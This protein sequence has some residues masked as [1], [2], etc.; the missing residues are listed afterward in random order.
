MGE[1][2]A[3]LKGA[4][5]LLV[6]D[7]SANLDVLC[8]LLEP[9]G[10][11]LAVATDGPMALKIASGTQPDLVLL[12]VMMPHMD[13]IE[14]C[15]RFKQDPKLRHIQVMF[16][17]A[18]DAAEDIVAGFRVGGIDYI[19]K[20]FRDEEVLVRVRT[21]LGLSLLHREL[22]SKN[23][24]LEDQNRKLAD[25]YRALE[26]EIE[27]RQKLKGQ[28]SMLSERDAER[29]GLDG[30]VG[31]SPTF[32][33]ILDEIRLMQENTA[34]SVI[35]SGESGTGKELVARAIHFGGERRHGPFIPVNCAS[36][37]A[38]LA[39]SLLFGHVRGAF[40]GAQSDR[41]GFFEM[42][43]GGTL[44]LDELGEM[45]LELQAQ[46]LRVL[47]DG[48]VWPVGARAGIQVE[49]RV[50]AATNL[51]LVDR[52]EAKAFRQ[53]LYFRLARFTVQIP[54]LRERSKDIPLL[55]YHFL[56]L[57]A[58]EMGREPPSFSP[59]ALE[60]LLAHPYPGNVREL[61][62]VVERA[63]IES[64]GGDV[65]PHHLHFMSLAAADGT[66]PAGTGRLVTLEENERRHILA[67]M[68]AANWV[69]RGEAGA[70]NIL[71]IPESTLR[72]RMKQL[73][74]DRP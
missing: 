7:A 40:T 21:Q 9:E 25:Q 4:Q 49:V 58:S 69:I 62:N 55:A 68:G 73:G 50:L 52:V 8:A 61:K 11:D 41:S 56:Q 33:A 66:A 6:D 37:P 22:E 38:E 48:Q 19:T 30:F 1:I 17:T 74:I 27:A 60:M 28:L 13:G 34:P 64:R 2:A 65:E 45:P 15:R 35:I 54:A 71:G 10:Y 39:E 67:A 29:W 18:R 26:E 5:I 14:V 46:L 42:A 44:F 23:Q 59:R 63:V 43:D 24:T 57:F 31:Q 47:E 12:D 3:D 20:P 51:N 16:I 72:G 36:M 53:D 32:K 70:A